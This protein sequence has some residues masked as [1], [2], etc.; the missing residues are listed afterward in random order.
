MYGE[1]EEKQKRG[2]GEVEERRRRGGGE[3]E[4]RQR[5]GGGE[6]E[7]RRRRGGE[8]AEK[9]R[10]RMATMP[11]GEEPPQHNTKEI[12]SREAPQTAPPYLRGA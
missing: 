11:E 3:T 9:R 1:M 5:R 2:G 6:P 4:K 7:E 10:R 12:G 8:E